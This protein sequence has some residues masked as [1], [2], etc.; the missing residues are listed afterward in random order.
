MLKKNYRN[1]EAIIKVPNEKFYD[2]KLQ[3]MSEF[4][5]KDNVAKICFFTSTFK[6][7]NK[8]GFPCEFWAVN[9]KEEQDGRS[10]R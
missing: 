5:H 4:A 3:A 10:P 6:K 9:A 2:N 8:M 7:G 1:H